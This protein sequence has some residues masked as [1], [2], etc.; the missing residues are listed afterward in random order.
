MITGQAHQVKGREASREG[1]ARNQVVGGCG[2]NG[3]KGL[4]KEKDRRNGIH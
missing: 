4:E 1:F 2:R 3:K